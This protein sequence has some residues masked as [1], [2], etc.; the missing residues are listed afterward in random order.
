MGHTIFKESWLFKV[1][2]YK[3]FSTIIDQNEQ[4]DAKITL[5]VLILIGRKKPKLIS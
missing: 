2:D 4:K 5:Q 1:Q 3:I